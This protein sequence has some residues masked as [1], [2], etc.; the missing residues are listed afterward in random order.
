M[1]RGDELK[2]Y[3]FIVSLKEI[4]INLEYYLLQIIT[5]KVGV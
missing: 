1:R 5:T 4:I 2:S 3:F